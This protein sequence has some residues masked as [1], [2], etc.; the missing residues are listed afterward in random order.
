MP[1]G[2]THDSITLWSLPLVAALTFD[3]T[4]SSSL[5]LMV[6][7]GFLFGG[8]MF[9][10]DLDIYSRQYLRWGPLRWIWLPYRQNMRHRSF[11]SH[12]PIVG[13]G[14]R[15]LYLITW[16]G[17]FGLAAILISAIVCQLVG[18]RDNGQVLA[19][20]LLN[21]SVA[22]VGRSL[23]Q[24]SAEWIALAIGL[25]LGAISH[26]LSDWVGSAYKRL[27]N[28]RSRSVKPPRLSPPAYSQSDLLENLP[29]EC[30]QE[31]PIPMSDRLPPSLQKTPPPQQPEVRSSNQSTPPIPPHLKRVPRLPPFDR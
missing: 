25:E 29:E 27:K 17:L 7:G 16:L 20:N 19:Q 31:E 22:W 3:R 8:L 13:T 5:T 6:S 10:P 21:G 15:V 26:S 14:L 18:N 9:G 1:S 2:R 28:L 4:R 24:N 30:A 12:G 11:L 23:Q